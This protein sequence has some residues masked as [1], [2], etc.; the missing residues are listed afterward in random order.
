MLLPPIRLSETCSD[1]GKSELLLCKLFALVAGDLYRSHSGVLF[2]YSNGS[3]A[4]AE[5]LSSVGLEF[6]LQALRRSQ[7]YCGIMWRMTTKRQYTDIVFEVR[8][9]QKCSDA[10][11][12]QNQMQEQSLA[13]WK[14]DIGMQN[15]GARSSVARHATAA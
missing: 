10:V 3:W 1:E 14:S 5:R 15:L 4:P 6:I 12:M 13:V 2:A 7:A 8:A 9:I 11:L